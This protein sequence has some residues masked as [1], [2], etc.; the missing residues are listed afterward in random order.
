MLFMDGVEVEIGGLIQSSLP[1]AFIEIT[2]NDCK[3]KIS[4]N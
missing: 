2:D 3:S 4:L 1:K